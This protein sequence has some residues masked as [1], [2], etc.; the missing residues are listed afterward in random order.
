MTLQNSIER[1]KAQFEFLFLNQITVEITKNQSGKKLTRTTKCYAN[2][3]SKFDPQKK[4]LFQTSQV[5]FKKDT[6][7]SECSISN[8]L[9]FIKQIINIKIQCIVIMSE[10]NESNK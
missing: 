3:C 6:N 9:Q 7:V 2:H 1:E 5:T 10:A 4:N 8:V